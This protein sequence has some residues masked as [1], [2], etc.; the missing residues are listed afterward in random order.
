IKARRPCLII[1]I[2]SF[3]PALETGSAP[4]PWEIGI[5]YNRDTR[6]ARLAI[7]ALEAAGIITGDNEPYSGR[8]LNTT[9]NRHGEANG[10]P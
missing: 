7:D 6:A 8:H 3:T 2:H 10:I 4:R 1:A 5:L 9:L